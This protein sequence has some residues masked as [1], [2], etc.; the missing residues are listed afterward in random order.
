MLL[1]GRNYFLSIEQKVQIAKEQKLQMSK[2]RM[3][4]LCIPKVNEEDGRDKNNRHGPQRE[5]TL[6]EKVSNTNLISQKC[7]AK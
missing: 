5:K 2:A 4:E 6:T 1:S 7:G 3:E